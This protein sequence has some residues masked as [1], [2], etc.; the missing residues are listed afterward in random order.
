MN[1]TRDEKRCMEIIHTR[2]R[3]HCAAGPSWP[4]SVYHAEQKLLLHTLCLIAWDESAL[5]ATET[6]AWHSY[7]CHAM[8]CVNLHGQR[9]CPG[10][11]TCC[12]NF[13]SA[14]A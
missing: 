10:E 5:S 4:P 3:V 8:P 6:L 7:R 13:P 12:Q 1:F 9:C 14:A 11:T 2:T